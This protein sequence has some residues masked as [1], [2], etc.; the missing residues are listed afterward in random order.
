AAAAEYLGHPAV[1]EVDHGGRRG[2]LRPRRRGEDQQRRQRE[3]EPH[4]APFLAANSRALIRYERPERTVTVRLD[5]TDAATATRPRP[6]A[7]RVPSQRSWVAHVASL[8]WL[9]PAAPTMRK[10]PFF[11]LA[12]NERTTEWPRPLIGPVRLVEAQPALA[13]GALVSTKS[14]GSLAR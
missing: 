12:V 14:V 3:R 8:A 4:H 13:P 11:A 6:T 5:P 10:M 7:V 2:Q 1:L 9:V